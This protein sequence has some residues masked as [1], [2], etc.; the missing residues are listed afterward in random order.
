ME[1]GNVENPQWLTLWHTYCNEYKLRTKEISKG[2]NEAEES[3]SDILGA[4]LYILLS[5]EYVSSGASRLH[6]L[7]ELQPMLGC[8]SAASR[9]GSRTEGRGSLQDAQRCRSG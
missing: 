3:V 1:R 6:I 2:K 9:G 5:N 4:S 8:E 7:G